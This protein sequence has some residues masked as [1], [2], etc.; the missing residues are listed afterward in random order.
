VLPIG[1]KFKNFDECS[2]Y[3]GK[4]N[5]VAISYIPQILFYTKNKVQPVY[6]DERKDSPGKLVCYYLKSDESAE[7]KRKWDATKEK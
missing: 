6:I 4:D 7:A 3:L 1:Y 5:L 2:G